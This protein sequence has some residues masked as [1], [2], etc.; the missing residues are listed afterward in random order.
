MMT[1]SALRSTSV[2]R[3]TCPAPGAALSSTTSPVLPRSSSAARIRLWGGGGARQD[4]LLQR[5]VVFVGLSK[6]GYGRTLQATR[7]GGVGRPAAPHPP[8]VVCHDT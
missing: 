6:R 5:L 7:P 4:L 8:P 3:S 2:T 1:S